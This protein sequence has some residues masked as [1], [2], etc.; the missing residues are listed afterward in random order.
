MFNLE[1]KTSEEIRLE[2]LAALIVEAGGEDKLAERYE[3]TSAFIKQMARGYK[4]SKS[5][6]GKGIGNA[7]ARRLEKAMNKDR[8]WL[9]HDHKV[10]FAQ[11][12]M[13]SYTVSTDENETLLL[14]AF[15]RASED[16][17]AIAI[18]WAKANTK[19]IIS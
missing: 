2:N 17:R 14:N 12:Q 11:Q 15:R 5:G 13:A 6:S 9:D 18:M 4:D 19:Q 1:M 3:C 10:F 8:G 7:A 16:Q